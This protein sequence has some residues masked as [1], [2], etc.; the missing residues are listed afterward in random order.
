MDDF[1]REFEKMYGVFNEEEDTK[2]DI[3]ADFF[4]YDFNSSCNVINDEHEDL[5]V[6]EFLE[7]WGKGF[8]VKNVSLYQKN[9]QN[10]NANLCQN[11]NQIFLLAQLYQYSNF[12]ENQRLRNKSSK[13]NKKV[14]KDNNCFLNNII[15]GRISFINPKSLNINYHTGACF[16]KRYEQRFNGVKKNKNK[17]NTVGKRKKVNNKIKEWLGVKVIDNKNIN[18]VAKDGG[19]FFVPEKIKVNQSNHEEILSNKHY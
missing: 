18:I 11:N 16:E 10:K 2:L 13:V 17:L 6:D 15:K 14:T 5:K 19:M 12:Y 9:N 3:K 8:P 4:C 7:K 1:N